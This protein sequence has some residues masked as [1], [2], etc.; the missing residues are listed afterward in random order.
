M[1]EY[2]C[3][4]VIINIFR[5]GHSKMGECGTFDNPAG[6]ALTLS[7]AISMIIIL[8]FRTN[9]RWIKYLLFIGSIPI[10]SILFITN[11]RIGIICLALN[12]LIL[13]WLLIH[14]FFNS[15]IAISFFF[16]TTAILLTSIVLY[17]TCNKTDSTTGRK[18]ILEQSLNIIKKHPII[19]YGPDGFQ[20]EYMLQQASFFKKNPNSIYENYADEVRYPMNEFMHLWINY[21]IGGPILLASLFFLPFI[22]S[23]R[24][25]GGLIQET[26]LPL[27][28]VILFSF[29]S[30]PFHYQSSWLVLL[31]VFSP[32]FYYIGRK[33]AISFIIRMYSVCL[34]GTL[35]ILY[36]SIDIYYEYQWRMTEKL[37]FRGHHKEALIRYGNLYGYFH[38]NKFF[39][40]SYA[41]A[42][43][44]GSDIQT[45]HKVI[46]ESGQH[47]N[48]YDRELLSGDICL[49]LN[50]YEEAL[51]H[52]SEAHYMCPVRFAPLEGLY[53]VYNQTGTDHKKDSIAKIIATKSVKVKSSDVERIKETCK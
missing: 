34:I 1:S 49:Y 16:S 43:F 32:I 7:I 25:K 2:E 23:L 21:G 8:L 6:L 52:F 29:F 47:W 30:Y 40:Y 10:V 41:I 42:A 45:A 46:K 28:S 12:V 50:E 33:V 51:E 39:L 18:F 20:S 13:L 3:A 53:K 48:G 4:Y 31:L 14:R 11:S 37:S 26:L 22:L 17:V 44:M 9:K 36:L 24:R 27:F 38:D 5:S 35:L 19:G 15:K